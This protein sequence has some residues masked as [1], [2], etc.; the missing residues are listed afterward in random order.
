MTFRTS[1]RTRPRRTPMTEIPANI[2]RADRPMRLKWMTNILRTGGLMSVALCSYQGKRVT[3]VR[4]EDWRAM[5][6]KRRCPGCEGGGIGIDGTPLVNVTLDI[7]E[8]PVQKQAD[9]DKFGGEFQDRRLPAVSKARARMCHGCEAAT[10][11][12]KDAAER[13]LHNARRLRAAL[14]DRKIPFAAFVLDVPTSTLQ[15]WLTSGLGD[16]QLKKCLDKLG[17]GKV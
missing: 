14:G 9:D 8:F 10:R 6:A 1:A 15:G 2:M 11:K 13:R 5:G 12:F 3:I 16:D 4:E 7:Y 17:E